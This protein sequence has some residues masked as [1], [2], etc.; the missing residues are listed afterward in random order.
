VSVALPAWRLSLM[1]A[2]AL[3]ILACSEDNIIGPENQLE[4]VNDT[5]SF[6]WQV[7]GLDNVSQTVIYFWEMTGTT[8]NVNQSGTLTGGSAT[9]TIRDQIHA[10]VY[11]ASLGTTGTFTT[12]TGTTGTWAIQVVLEGATG[13]LNFRVENP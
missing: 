4:V 2:A 7:T 12:S 3:V 6:E 10:E 1:L 9:V 8:A 11:T 13:T 5:N